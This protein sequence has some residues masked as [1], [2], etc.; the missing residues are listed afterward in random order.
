MNAA[1]ET[2]HRSRARFRVL[3]Q[4]ERGGRRPATI[5]IDRRS[6]LLSVR[7]LRS[8]R[9]YVLPLSTVAEIVAAKVLKA[10]LVQGGRLPRRRLGPRRA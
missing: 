5:T 9:E 7:P 10:E 3:A 2:T 4:I 1:A 6:G 8:R